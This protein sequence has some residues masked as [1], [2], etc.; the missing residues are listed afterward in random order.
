MTPSPETRIVDFRRLLEELRNICMERDTG[1]AFIVTENNQWAEVRIEGGKI[2]NIKFRNKRG[3]EALRLLKQVDKAKYTFKAGELPPKDD[4]AVDDPNSPYLPS[5]FH[6]FQLLGLDAAS[7]A[8]LQNQSTVI[9]KPTAVAATTKHVVAKKTILVVE[10]SAISRKV[11]VRTLADKNYEI[12]ETEDGFQALA[13]LGNATPDI[14][15]LDLVLPGIDGY[16]VLAHMRKKPECADVPVIILTA[17]DTLLD[18]LRGK[19]SDADE[20]LTKPFSPADLLER[21]E[22]HLGG[23]GNG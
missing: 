6:I 7:A 12:I 23:G 5:T 20:Y 15:L 11:I 22:K 4:V 14:V 17:R 16:K 3:I 13:A 8:P 18:K 9:S 19:M 21:V 10:D 1:T 2:T